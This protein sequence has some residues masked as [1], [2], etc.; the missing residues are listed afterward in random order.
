MSKQ[1][2]ILIIMRWMMVLET[3]LD[4]K[5]ALLNSNIDRAYL[6]L[7]RTQFSHNLTISSIIRR[8]RRRSLRR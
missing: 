6:P 7:N 2:S 1:L 4:I 3:L 8:R 5:L